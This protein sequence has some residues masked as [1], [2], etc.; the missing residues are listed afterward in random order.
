VIFKEALG[1][2]LS[3]YFFFFDGILHIFQQVH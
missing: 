3:I 1:V 2:A